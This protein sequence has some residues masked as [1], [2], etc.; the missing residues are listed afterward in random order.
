MDQ[1]LYVTI[2]CY[3]FLIFF[4]GTH[5][6]FELALDYLGLGATAGALNP[7]DILVIGCH[8]GLQL[9]R[10]GVRLHF[11]VYLH[12]SSFVLMCS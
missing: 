11:G 3:I 4:Y 10:E 7:H 8:D 6:I 12:H 2:Y 9:L 5:F 1:S